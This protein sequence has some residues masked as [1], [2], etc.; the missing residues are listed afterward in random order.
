MSQRS[1]ATG[2]DANDASMTRDLGLF[3]KN[4]VANSM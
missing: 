1:Q 4:G 2:P 3:M